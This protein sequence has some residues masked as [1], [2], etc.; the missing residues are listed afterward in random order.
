VGAAAAR[1]AELAPEGLDLAI[2]YLR[3]PLSPAVLAPLAEA[4]APLA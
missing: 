1:V 2:V 3:E 4:L